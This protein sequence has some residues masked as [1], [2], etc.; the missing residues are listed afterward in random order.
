MVVL[1]AA[2]ELEIAGDWG[3]HAQEGR[4][5]GEAAHALDTPASRPRA[6]AQTNAL[7]LI[8][9]RRPRSEVGARQRQKRLANEELVRRAEHL[10]PEGR[11]LVHAHFGLGMDV[12]ALATVH[13]VTPRQMRRRLDRLQSTV[14]D[15]CFL[16]TARFAERLSPAMAALARAYWIEGRT[17]RE[18]ARIRRET[19]YAIRRTL[20]VARSMLLLALSEQTEVPAELAAAAF[21]A[22]R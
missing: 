11:Q 17:L 2:A 16:L 4:C 7:P 20:D 1:D 9:K 12:E 22:R 21:R 18:L 14:S 13:H 8:K 15:P 19:L 6:K 5:P 10:P 3:E